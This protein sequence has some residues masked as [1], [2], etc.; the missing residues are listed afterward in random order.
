MENFTTIKDLRVGDFFVKVTKKGLNKVVYQKNKFDR[1]NKAFECNPV[2][3]IFN[4]VYLK[5]S[6][7]VCEVEY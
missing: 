2:D 7:L 6:A 3:D 1:S 4:A 5:S